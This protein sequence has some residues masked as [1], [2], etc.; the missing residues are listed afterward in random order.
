MKFDLPQQFL[1]HVLWNTNNNNKKNPVKL[2]SQWMKFLCIFLISPR[3]T[4][5]MQ[6][7]IIII[8]I[9]KGMLL[10]RAILHFFLFE[11]LKPEDIV[12]NRRF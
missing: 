12:P 7:I 10:M 11:Y 9:A 1:L 2:L 4:K 8:I 5:H 3:K 6:I